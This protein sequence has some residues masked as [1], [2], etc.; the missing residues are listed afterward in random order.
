[1]LGRDP[2]VLAHRSS[3]DR[4]VTR[5][6]FA[7]ACLGTLWLMG[8][9]SAASAAPQVQPSLDIPS[10][11]AGMTGQPLLSAHGVGAQ[12]YECQPGA[13]GTLTWMFREPIATLLQGDK[14]IGR[15]TAGPN[16]DLA[17]GSGVT[18]KVVA[19]APGATPGDIPQLELQVV[20]RRHGGALDEAGTV[21]RLHTAGGR[22]A[23]ACDSAGEFRSVPYEADYV[24]LR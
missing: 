12:I 20:G 3:Q 2:G 16:W 13:A 6:T 14:T 8:L 1:M 11:F 15:H 24:F 17:D 19:S 10:A 18:G 9:L 23:G 5:S 4:L 22:L 7:T 21:L